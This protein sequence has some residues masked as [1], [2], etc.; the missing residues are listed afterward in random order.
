M[1]E[2]ET[3]GPATAAAAVVPTAATETKEKKPA[4]E[5][6]AVEEVEDLFKAADFF[7]ADEVEVEKEL[8]FEGQGLKLNTEED[9]KGKGHGTAWTCRVQRRNFWSRNRELEPVYFPVSS[10]FLPGICSPAMRGIFGRLP[11]F[12]PG[13]SSLSRFLPVLKRGLGSRFR[14]VL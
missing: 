13:F 12:L 2:L 8:S 10:C 7:P 6:A 14:L 11:R 5:T 3:G 1:V 9:A 4:T